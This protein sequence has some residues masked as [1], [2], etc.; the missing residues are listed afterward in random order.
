MQVPYCIPEFNYAPG[1]AAKCKKG[2][3]YAF[4]V[5]LTQ[6]A[7]VNI[8]AGKV[9]GEVVDH[10]VLTHLHPS[11][12]GST[13]AQLGLSLATGWRYVGVV[14][15]T[16]SS[17]G[18]A[19]ALR[20]YRPGYDTI[21]LKPG[22]KVTELNWTAAPGMSAQVKAVDDLMNG[23]PTQKSG[24][25]TARQA[26][27]PGTRSPAQKEALLFGAGEYTRLANELSPADPG[28]TQILDK[29]NRLRSLADGKKG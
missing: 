8:G 13:S 9:T 20:F 21:V 14:N 18:H 2:E 29:A 5:D 28:R 26:L 15:Y 22:E 7:E 27:E 16:S 12:D 10:V 3:V 17:T 24:A 6:T 25:V 11:T 1:V 4:R 19:I 23:P